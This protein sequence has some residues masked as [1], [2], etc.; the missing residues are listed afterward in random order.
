MHKVHTDATCTYRHLPCAETDMHTQY[1]A[2]VEGCLL[3]Y[4]TGV[5]VKSF[6]W[7]TTS[8][9]DLCM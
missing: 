7:L 4:T 3:K 2:G 6:V 5:L 9:T 1:V 8:V